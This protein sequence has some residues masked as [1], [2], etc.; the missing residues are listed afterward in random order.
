M[1]L[2][3]W[4]PRLSAYLAERRRMPFEWGSHDC[5]MFVSGAIDAVTGDDPA[6][7]FRGTYDSEYGAART[8]SE[9]GYQSPSDV[10]DVSLSA[11]AIGFAKRGDIVENSD[12]SLGVVVGKD[13]VFVGDNGFERMPVR[14][15]VKAWANG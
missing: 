14:D 9:A 5:A 6:S 4:E 11:I 12:G 3:D 13:A 15:C 1:R 7:V 2:K 10:V 8:L